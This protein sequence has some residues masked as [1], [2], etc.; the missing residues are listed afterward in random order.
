M[1]C[2][3]HP[4]EQQAGGQGAAHVPAEPAT[5]GGEPG[6]QEV[7][8]RVPGLIRFHCAARWSLHFSIETGLYIFFLIVKIQVSICKYKNKVYFLVCWCY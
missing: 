3:C 5:Q 7:E 6:A 2:P 4:T 8:G 1:S